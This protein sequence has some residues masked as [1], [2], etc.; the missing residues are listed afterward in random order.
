[1]VAHH[2]LVLG[3]EEATAKVR[4]VE[5]AIH[6]EEDMEEAVS[7][8][9]QVATVAPA[10]EGLWVEEEVC[11]GVRHLLAIINSISQVDRTHMQGRQ[12]S[13]PM[14]R[15]VCHHRDIH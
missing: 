14:L 6:Q 5:E 4:Q 2:P 3:E 12:W 9:G 11:N 13:A 8:A 15:G 7:E 10:E 1:M